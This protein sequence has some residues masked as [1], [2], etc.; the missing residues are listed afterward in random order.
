MPNR[1][2]TIGA[3]CAL[4][5]GWAM[6]E[7]R[8]TATGKVA[9]DGGRPVEHAT[10]LVYE[11]HVK[12]GYGVYCPS[13]WADCGKRAVTDAEGNFT[14][15]GLNPDLVFKLLVVKDGYSAAFVDKVDPAEGPALTASLKTRP[16]VEDTS[17]LVRGRV[18]D[19]HGNPVKD[20]V[21]E[22]N[23]LLMQ[24]G[25]RRFGSSDGWIDPMAV[26]NEKGEFEIAYGKPA[27]G[28]ILNVNARGMAPRLFT[29]PTGPDRKTLTVTE[30][31]TIRGRLVN[32]DGKPVGDAEVGVTSHSHISGTYIS[33]VRIGTHPDGTFAITNIPAGRVWDVYPKMESLAARALAANPVYCET[34]DD[35]QEVNVGDIQLRPSYTL[36]GK[37]MLSDGKSIPPNMRMT[38]SRGGSGDDVQMTSLA[39]DGKFEFTGLAPDVYV[40]GAGVRG[41]RPPEGETG[42]VLVDHDRKDVVIRI[43][44]TPPRR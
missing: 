22:Q 10:V 8:A 26:S 3:A 35:G 2:W 28:M 25:G 42:E 17:Q 13:C 34:S 5:G 32:P 31:A 7:E 20:A 36:R 40:L 39:T 15:P 44:P 18:V 6:A 16:A 30:G 23:G 29:E 4:A 12:K 37:V 14:I 41:Y 19:A 21:V 38:L 11:G 9:D 27:A 43:E 33:E 24:G 1:F